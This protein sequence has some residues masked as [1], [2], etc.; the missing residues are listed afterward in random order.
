MNSGF[1]LETKENLELIFNTIPDAAIISRLTDGLVV[2]VN[3]GFTKIT[4]FKREEIIGTSGDE[5]KLWKNPEERQSVVNELLENGVCENFEGTF[6]RKNGSTLTGLV[7]AK[8]F[9]LHDVL[10]IIG[11]V[12]DISER[13][14]AETSLIE[15]EEKYRFL[16]ENTKDVIWVLDPGSMYLTYI[17]PSVETL[18]GY[19]AH[20]LKTIPFEEILIP[21]IRE[22]FLHRT[23]Q[24]VESFLASRET[25]TGYQNEV[26]H[27]RKDGSTVCTEVVN[28]YYLN[29]TTGKVEIQGMSRDITERKKSEQA[30]RDSEARFRSY[31]E[32]PLIGITITSLE[33]GWI[34]ANK[35]ISDMLGYSMEELSAL[36][37]ADLTYPDDLAAD[38]EQ[39]T[40]VLSDQQDTYFLEKR[41]I[42]KNKEII[43]THLSVGCVRKPDRSVD[44]M[45][46]LLQDIS[47]RKLAEEALRKSEEKFRSLY[48]NMSEGSAM[49]TLVYND[50]GVPEDYLIMEVNPAFE[51]QLG[52]SREMVINNTSREAYGV[53]EPPYFEIYSRVARTGHPE[54]FDALFVPIGKHFSISV[55][56]PYKDSFATIFED[57]TDRKKGEEVL[58]KTIFDAEMA[59]NAKSIFLANISHE[60]RTPLNAII[61]FSQLMNRDKTLSEVQKEYNVSI[62][63]AGEHLLTLINDILELAKVEAGR[64]V[65]NPANV[66]LRMFFKDIQLIFKERAQSKKLR[67]VFEISEN[68]PRHVVIDESKLRQIFINLI[69]NAIK[70]TDEGVVNVLTSYMKEA[71]GHGKLI[72][73]IQDS[74]TGIAEDE[75]VN[76]FKPFVQTTTGIKKGSGTGLGLALSRELAMLMGGNITVTS[77]VGKGSL[78][79]LHVALEEGHFITGEVNATKHV[80]GLAKSQKFHRILVAD[81]MPENLQTVVSLLRM[82]G[83]ETNEAVNGK[84]ALDKFEQWVPDLII[85]DLRMPVMDGFEATR[86][87]RSTEKGAK[88][89]V[90][91]LSASTFEDDRKRIEEIGIQDFISKPFR[92]NDLFY[93][94]GKVL[95][96]SYIYEDETSSEQLYLN[97]EEV[98]ASN[99]KQ[100]PEVLRLK[101]LETLGV[102]DIRL[103][104]KL[105]NSMDQN[106]SSL[107]KLLMT[108]ARNYDY[109]RLKMILTKKHDEH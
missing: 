13:K 23:R 98:I 17:S 54:V 47:Q 51:A 57:I 3:D 87:L 21:E 36:T 56:S 42:C 94:I 43:W 97:D 8:S 16:A 75:L 69:D 7:S 60:I 86:R 30:L 80:V 24:R 28:Y 67:F 58:L 10:H 50:Q 27:L 12:R 68:L 62:I 109:D 1:L 78:F 4:G 106:N 91:A 104:K 14:K 15:S 37:W 84:D 64:V 77:A 83:F 33:K 85:M 32:L 82:V 81:D 79:T 29:K 65:L 11:I 45:V 48:E 2:A 34:E 41:F 61:G 73:E 71:N 76:L 22:P 90:I 72:V 105:I 18:L 63:R 95:D 25:G 102:A 92:E 88:T 38:E 31:F 9:M 46:A 74:G 19:T 59:N 20:E 49:H 100:L 99:V 44:Y 53:K 40:R 35:G 93:S 5:I 108:L 103:L 70:F 66:D 39:F 6:S 89:P 107:A 52:I 96:I 55:Y 26:I 101:M